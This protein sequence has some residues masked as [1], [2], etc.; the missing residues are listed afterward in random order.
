M[1]LALILFGI[2]YAEHIKHWTGK[3]L[4]INY[5]TSVD[6]YKQYLF[7][8]FEN[9]GYD[10]DIFLSTYKSKKSKELLDTYKPKKYNLFPPL[11]YTKKNKRIGKNSNIIKAIEIAIKHS[12]NINY[13]YDLCV[14]TRFDLN[15]MID[16][17]EKNVNIKTDMFNV[18]S[19]LRV[20]ELICD[21]FY[22]IP[23]SM[24]KNFY[25]VLKRHGL[26]RSHHHIKERI[27]SF[28]S[29]N[30]IL[31]EYVDIRFLSFYKIIRHESIVNQNNENK[32]IKR[33][34][35]NIKK[36]NIDK[37]KINKPIVSKNN[38]PNS[39]AV[40]ILINKIINNKK[41]IIIKKIPR[42]FNKIQ[43]KSLK[44]NKILIRNKPTLKNINKSTKK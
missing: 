1:K 8:Y 39:N 13:K 41:P 23:W 31:N 17:N 28:A 40:K 29:I 7:K 14:I 42:K 34:D 15:F 32:N 10:I 4:S 11:K 24:I 33:H 16:F 20:H 21:N 19:Q 3:E 6:N 27:E 5:K 18:V 9:L 2:S 30:Y 35:I 44:N 37:N 36:N 38:K 22:I 25:F 26:N 12:K 43:I